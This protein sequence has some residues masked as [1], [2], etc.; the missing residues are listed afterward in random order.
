VSS[1][2]DRWIHD[3]ES[4]HLA[5]LTVPEVA[6]ALRALSTAYVE[7]RSAIGARRVLDG[8]GKRAAFALYYGPVHFL[9][10]SSV[11]DALAIDA[12]R[13]LPVLDLG[14]GT[15]AVGAAVA[16]ST[17]ARAVTGIDTHPWALDQARHTYAV[18]GLAATL[19]RASVS[20]VRVPKRPVTIA[21]GYVV[22]ELA[23]DERA[24][25]LDTLLAAARAGS[26]LVVVEP[27]ARG[28]TPWWTGWTDALTTVAARADEWKLSVDPPAIVRKL[29]DAAGLTATQVNIRTLVIR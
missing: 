7:R 8:A 24:R 9:A 2:F 3:L 1:P 29:G 12:G 14:C 13:P 21:A 11:L 17:G 25:L 5:D 22:N 19:S 10:V 18:F 27:L 26:R 20:R 23:D 15:G 28:A 4:R 16:A 6:R